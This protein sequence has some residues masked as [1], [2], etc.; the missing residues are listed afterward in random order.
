MTGRVLVCDE[1]YPMDAVCESL[2]QA[3]LRRAGTFR[4]QVRVAGEG[5][6]ND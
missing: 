6:F 4:L 1:W 5:R 2:P 3:E